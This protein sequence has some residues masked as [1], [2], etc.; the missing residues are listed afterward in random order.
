MESIVYGI[1]AILLRLA[2]PIC[3]FPESSDSTVS[4][5]FRTVRAKLCRILP[6]AW[7]RFCRSQEC[8]FNVTVLLQASPSP[9]NYIT[10]AILQGHCS[11]QENRGVVPE[12]RLHSVSSTRGSGKCVSPVVP[13]RAVFVV[14]THT[15]LSHLLPSTYSAGTAPSASR[16]T[17]VVRDVFVFSARTRAMRYLQ[18]IT[19]RFLQ[20]LPSE[21][22]SGHVHCVEDAHWE[23]SAVPASLP[24]QLRP[25][26][27]KFK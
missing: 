16:G 2:R 12:F 19:Y 21:G 22:V 1:R 20:N 6:H 13:R 10:A 4:P 27:V 15:Q 5:L 11:R 26:F 18:I 8:L 25:M 17:L 7:H 3:H 23:G 9:G 24:P 14:L